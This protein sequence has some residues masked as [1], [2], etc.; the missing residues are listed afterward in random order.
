MLEFE[1]YKV[2]LNSMKPDLATIA[3]ALKLEDLKNEQEVEEKMALNGTV[4]DDGKEPEA[5]TGDQKE[6][7]VRILELYFGKKLSEVTE[8]DIEEKLKDLNKEDTK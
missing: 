3:S 8:E 5:G 1:E 4:A 7:A 2:K 6:Q